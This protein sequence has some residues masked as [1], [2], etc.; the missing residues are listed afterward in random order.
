[1][2]KL[3][4]CEVCGAPSNSFVENSKQVRVCTKACTKDCKGHWERDGEPKWYCPRH[5]LRALARRTRKKLM[6]FA[7]DH[8]GAK[9]LQHDPPPPCQCSGAKLSRAVQ[10]RVGGEVCR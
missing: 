1:M 5:Y 10:D 4:K 6:W 7:C 2:Q 8:C 3:P 9:L